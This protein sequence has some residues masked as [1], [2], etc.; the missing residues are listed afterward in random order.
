MSFLAKLTLGDN[1]YTVL[2]ADY[3]VSQ[4]VGERN[5]PVRAPSIGLIHLTLES[6]NSGEI[7][8]WAASPRLSKDGNVVF[9][10]RDAQSSMKTL[11]FRGGFCVNYREQ[12]DAN[13]DTPMRMHI[14]LAVHEIEC[15]GVTMIE[16]WPGFENGQSGRSS[17]GGN[18]SSSSQSSSSAQSDSGSI[19]SFIP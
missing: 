8:E 4:P 12:F 5:M 19:P 9:Y 3:E 2:N 17:S 16:Q 1:S 11:S 13:N 15:T 10:R 7:F 18:S 14:T 6:T